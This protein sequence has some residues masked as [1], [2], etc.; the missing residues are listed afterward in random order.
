[1]FRLFDELHS[2]NNIL[3]KWG[4]HSIS[5]DDTSLL[6]HV[7]GGGPI[8]SLV[9]G[10]S[11]TDDSEIS[12]RKSYWYHFTASIDK[13]TDKTLLK[14]LLYWSEIYHREDCVFNVFYP[15]GGDRHLKHYRRLF[16]VVDYPTLIVTDNDVLPNDYLALSPEFMSEG[17]LGNEFE[18]LRNVLE[19]LHALI[20]DNNGLS[21]VKRKVI[22]NKMGSSVKK[23]WKELK[24]LVSISVST[25]D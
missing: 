17:V 7:G 22:Q 13:A 21:K 23:G 4:D 15:A 20:V 3:D 16:N 10:K 6:F 11:I 12:T 2:Y 25:A 9:E 18:D 8:D 24:S 5:R 1:M 19:N 14:E